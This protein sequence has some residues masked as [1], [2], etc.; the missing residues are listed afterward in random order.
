M[1][2]LEDAIEQC[3]AQLER[4]VRDAGHV[5]TGDGRVSEEIAARLIGISTRHLRRLRHLGE[6]TAHRLGVNGARVSYRL[7]E[8][9]RFIESTRDTAE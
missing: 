3:R 6:L 2:D 7:R 9:A 5:V 8:V 4:A 1:T